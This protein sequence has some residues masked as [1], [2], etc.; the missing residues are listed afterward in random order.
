MH[1][2]G[3]DDV[4]G[5]LSVSLFDIDP[6]SVQTLENIDEEKR[7]KS[8]L[9]EDPSALLSTHLNNDL[10]STDIDLADR[11]YTFSETFQAHHKS[12]LSASDISFENSSSIL[13]W[14]NMDLV[15]HCLVQEPRSTRNE[16][17]GRFWRDNEGCH[18]LC[19]SAYA[20]GPT[21]QC[22][23]LAERLL[24][25]E[26]GSCSVEA[27]VERPSQTSPKVFSEEVV[28]VVD[29]SEC[30]WFEESCTLNSD[31]LEDVTGIS[32]IEESKETTD[33]MFSELPETSNFKDNSILTANEVLDSDTELCANWS[34]LTDQ[35]SYPIEEEPWEEQVNHHTC[36]RRKLAK[37]E[38]RDALCDDEDS[39]YFKEYYFL[40]KKDSQM[41]NDTN[42]KINECDKRYKEVQSELTPTYDSRTDISTTYLWSSPDAKSE[43]HNDEF[44]ETGIV[45]ITSRAMTMSKIGPGISARTLF[46]SGATSSMINKQFY[47]ENKELHKYPKYK[48]SG[49]K[50]TIADGSQLLVQEAVKIV[51]DL[52]GHFFEIIVYLFNMDKKIDLIVG[53]KSATELESVID[54]GKLEFRFKKRSLP[55]FPSKDL[56]V[57][58][59]KTTTYVAQVKSYPPDFDQAQVVL[60]MQGIR[61]DL[62]PQTIQAKMIKSEILLTLTNKSDSLLFIPKDQAI[63]AVDM[64]SAGYFYL[65]RGTIQQLMEPRFILIE[66][67]LE[68]HCNDIFET[69]KISSPFHKRKTSKGPPDT[70]LNIKN[71]DDPKSDSGTTYKAGFKVDPND[72]WPWLD[73]DDPRRKMTDREILEKYIDLSESIMTEQQKSDLF[74]LM[75]EHREAFSL[76]DE[77]GECPDMEI[78]LELEDKTPFFNRP[79][80]IKEQEKEIVDREMRKGCLLGILKKGLSSYSSPIMLIP[81]KQGGIPRIVTDFR[82]LN[83][84][85]KVLQCSLPLVR[86]AI[87][88]LGAAESEI[89]SII[90]LRDA[91][92]TL[93]VALKSQPF[94]GITP[95]YGSPTYIYQRLG[96]GLSVSPSI[97]MHFITKVLDELE[98]RKNFIGIMD[99]IFV[100]S[101]IVDHLQRLKELFTVLIRN[102]LKISIKKCQFF[103]K[104]VVY[105]GHLFS[106]E[107]TIPC[108]TPTK[109]KI[110]AICRIEKLTNVKSVRSFCGMVNFQAMYLKALQ[111]IL[112]PLYNLLKKNKKWA[113][114]QEC[115]NA[116][117]KIKKMIS[118]PP[119][120]VMPNT[121][122]HFTL[123]SDTSKIATG[124]A[125]YQ[126]QEGI[127]RL[128]AYNSKRLFEAAVRYSI[129]ELELLGLTINITSFKIYLKCVHF[130]VIIN[131]SALVQIIKSKKEPPTLRMKKLLEVLSQYNFTVKFLKGKEMFISDFLSRHP[132]NDTSSPHEIIP[133]SFRIHEDE[134]NDDYYIAFHSSEFHPDKWFSDLTEWEETIISVYEQAFV[135]TRSQSKKEN[136]PVANIYP[137]KGKFKK[138]E[139]ETPD[140]IPA[141]LP[142]PQPIVQPDP[143]PEPIQLPEPQLEP[144][145]DPVRLPRPEP[146]RK[147]RRNEPVQMPPRNPNPMIPPV[148]TFFRTPPIPPQTQIPQI[149]TRNATTGKDPTQGVPIVDISSKHPLDIRL[150]GY[151]PRFD[152]F[153]PNKELDEFRPPDKELYN[154]KQ[155]LLTEIKDENIFRDHLPKQIELDKFM[156]QLKMKVL[157]NYEIPLSAKELTQEIKRSPF[158]KDIY[159]CVTL[160]KVPSDLKG[161]AARN[162]QRESEMYIVI[163]D[164]L[165]R[166]RFPSK[167]SPEL[168]LL[169]CIP[170]RYI[171]YLLYYYHDSLLAGHQGVL[172]M[173]L[174][175]RERFFVPNLFHCIRQYVASCSDCQMTRKKE[176][177]PIAQHKRIPDDFRPMARLSCDI[178]EMPKSALGHKYILFT[179]C[180]VSN[181]VIGTALFKQDSISIAEALLNRVIY[182]FG[183]P[184]MIIM[185]EAKTSYS[186]VMMIIYNALN[187]KPILISC[188]NH[189]SLRTERYIR[190]ISE[191]LCKHMTDKGE[192]WHL[193]INACCYAHN[194]YVTP[195]TGYSPFEI[196]YLHK[197]F[198]LVDL[199]FNPY[200]GTSKEVPDYIKFMKDRFTIISQVVKDKKLHDQQMQ[201]AKQQRIFEKEKGFAV[202]DLVYV[203]APTKSSLETNSR[204]FKREWIGPVQVQAVLDKT[205]YLLADWQG[206]ILPFFGSV[207]ISRMKHCSINLGQMKGKQLLTVYNLHDLVREWIKI[208]GIPKE[209]S[210]PEENAKSNPGQ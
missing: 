20:Y 77:I 106:Y 60:K 133:I 73:P 80:P 96:M 184:E 105:M 110:D 104:K 65:S 33:P 100:H 181:Y 88:Q 12:G 182:Q 137:L 70:K 162:L 197:P 47:E 76:R 123:V 134:N 155:K 67:S 145:P 48:V 24:Q 7:Q 179:T 35:L 85:L 121:T 141:P 178:K 14:S 81:R 101:K 50:V 166:I 22:L 206:K 116:L 27:Q 42:N 66:E 148:P 57:P 151:L 207:H 59:N 84:R 144:Q 170:E 82:F 161:K 25:S 28:D 186:E 128:V 40:E 139:Y 95:Y 193:Y 94:L 4:D 9:P 131:H 146:P 13:S 210:T 23:S 156:K 21:I 6:P 87:Q 205:H 124:A 53:M 61:A 153:D 117:E 208:Y 15:G 157:N 69:D 17:L 93:R 112:A 34:I 167:N 120:L 92:H 202:G 103:R 138:P 192:N 130:S 31:L 201:I 86:D 176:Q 10:V 143:I 90:D 188:N 190:T 183:C 32:G 5:I 169:L 26:S 2:T 55:I 63:G 159:K 72:K 163:E 142:P 180:E 195:T 44:L 165:F 97:F 126:E 79:Y 171:P 147:I 111:T 203:L 185:D 58:P 75:M 113:W 52:R 91:Y 74:D 62:L 109:S 158:F 46:D 164:V 56:R 114:T 160:N 36:A 119:V 29:L 175:L 172:R 149:P 173:Y 108:I 11:T 68:D 132:G 196:V 64:R 49:I 30:D 174:T 122:G 16:T 199:R 135:T 191:M 37:W 43:L 140:P 45:P 3:N 83:S 189:G 118:N 41:T 98:H 78:E 127:Q 194:T 198:D 99:D 19:S 71:R 102:G 1:P 150:Q 129:S 39:E 125:L 89:A 187:I 136:K 8:P 168:D 115:Q 154:K 51:V 152:D 38:R 107:G 177:S 200:K 209:L 204:K 54:T 18:T